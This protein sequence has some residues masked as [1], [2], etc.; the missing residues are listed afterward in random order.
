MNNPQRTTGAY[1]KYK[2]G[3]NDQSSILQLDSYSRTQQNQHTFKKQ[4]E[5]QDGNWI[6]SESTPPRPDQIKSGLINQSF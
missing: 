1:K 2:M 4:E 3:T 5:E 6:G